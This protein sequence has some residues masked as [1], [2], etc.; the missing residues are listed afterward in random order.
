[1]KIHFRSNGFYSL[2]GDAIIGV[3]SAERNTSEINHRT[4]DPL[5]PWRRNAG[6]H[7]LWDRLRGEIKTIDGWAVG[8]LELRW[9]LF[10]LSRIL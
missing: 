4:H 6:D 9:N 8:T 5:R 2:P 3:T 7:R 1:M 10:S